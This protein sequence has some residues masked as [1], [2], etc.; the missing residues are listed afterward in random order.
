MTTQPDTDMSESTFACL[1]RA[2]VLAKD[3]QVARLS[4][5][6]SMLEREGWEEADITGAIQAW[7]AYENGKK[8]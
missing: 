6:R 8:A 5:L 1:T 4:T 3:R 7:S 2:V